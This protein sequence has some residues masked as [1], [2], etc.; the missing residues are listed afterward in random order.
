MLLVSDKSEAG[1]R[2]LMVMSV[3]KPQ[4]T[5]SQTHLVKMANVAYEGK[6]LVVPESTAS[7]SE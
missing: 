4:K 7:E 5:I 1:K 2:H 6:E 3:G